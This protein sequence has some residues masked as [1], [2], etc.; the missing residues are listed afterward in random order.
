MSQKLQINQPYTE[1][2]LRWKELYKIGAISSFV[3]AILV[4]FAIIAYLIW[5]FTAGVVSTEEIFILLQNDLLGGLM[6]LDL[7]L[8]VTELVNILMVLALYVSLK[9]VNESYAL[10]AFILGLI[11]VILII[12]VRPLADLVYLSDQYVATT[13]EVV[14]NQ[15]LAA[16]EA[17]LAIFNGTAWM[18]F[19]VFL[20]LSG[21]ISSVLMLR[22]HIFKKSTAI[23]GLIASIPGLV[24]FIPVVGTLLLFVGTIGG[25][26][27][28]FM[29]AWD[30]Y[31]FRKHF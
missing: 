6:S 16:G 20:A 18:I 17:L 15:Y 29:V 3:I 21:L 31:Q 13:S 14:K 27:W 23:T 9:Q 24:F 10:I 1:E 5:P 28:C 25:I 8:L 4:I 7:L 11:A 2:D 12:A 26:V 22:S 19:T 30:F